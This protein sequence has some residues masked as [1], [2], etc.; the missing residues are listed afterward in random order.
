MPI[1]LKLP[2]WLADNGVFAEAK[3]PPSFRVRVTARVLLTPEAVGF[4]L[5]LVKPICGIS[6]C[7][8]A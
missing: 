3:L 8:A 6:A 2:V 5:M 4:S 7:T 1:T